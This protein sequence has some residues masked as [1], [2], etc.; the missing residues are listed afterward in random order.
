MSVDCRNMQ[1]WTDIMYM[2]LRVHVVGLIKR[3]IISGQLSWGVSGGQTEPAFSQCVQCRIQNDTTERVLILLNEY[4]RLQ[5]L[6][7]VS[8]IKCRTQIAQT[9]STEQS[10]AF[11]QKLVAAKMVRLFSAYCGFGL[12]IALPT[13]TCRWTIFR[14]N[15]IRSVPSE[16][17]PLR[18]VLTFRNLASYIQDGRKITLQMHHF[19]FIRQITVLNILNM[20]YNLHFCLFKMPFIS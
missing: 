8:C 3:I 2:Y 6:L 17:V 15:F 11:L 1:G 14:R 5:L 10:R 9:A 7:D 4:P 13:V 19:I 16:P 18:F 12:V 20:L